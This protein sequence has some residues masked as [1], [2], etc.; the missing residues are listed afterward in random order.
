MTSVNVRSQLSPLATASA[1]LLAMAMLGTCSG[2]GSSVPPVSPGVP[3]LPSLGSLPLSLAS[4]AVTGSPLES[5]SGSPFWSTASPPAVTVLAIGP[6][7]RVG[8]TSTMNS[9]VNESPIANNEAAVWSTISVVVEP[10]QLAASSVMLL[11]GSVG[12][13]T[14][15]KP[16][17]P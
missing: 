12:P 1:A 16:E 17:P 15:A 13:V 4:E 10:S 8:S 3:G 6:E 7:A 2:V 14:I 9:I 11:A 5:V